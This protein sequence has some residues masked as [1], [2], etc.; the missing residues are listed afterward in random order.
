[1]KKELICFFVLILFSF[2]MVDAAII[3]APSCSYEDVSTAVNSANYEDTVIVPAGTCTWDKTLTITK[4][5]N[6]QGAGIDKTIVRSDGPSGTGVYTVNFNADQATALNNYAF[7]LS[8]FTFQQV[9]ALYGCLE[10]SNQNIS[11]ELTNVIVHDNKFIGR[12]GQGIGIT[13]D[14]GVFGV[15]YNNIIQDLSHSWRFLGR[16]TGWTHVDEWVPGSSNAMYYEDNYIFLTSDLDSSLIVSGGGGNR[17]VARYNTINLSTKPYN[18]FAQAYDI[19]GNQENNHGAGVGLEIY[20]NHRIS[21]SGRWLDHRG[22]KVF[23]FFNRWTESSG[24][25]SLNVWEEF[26]DDDFIHIACPEDRYART[27]AGNCVQRPRNSYYWRNYGG[28]DGTK[29][30]NQLNILFDHYS[31]TTGELNNPLLLL[32]NDG[33]FRDNTATFDG[34]ID[35]IGSCGY[36]NGPACTK[37]G[38]GC[39]TLEQMNAIKPTAP[40]LGFWVTNQSCTNL[41]DMTGKNPFNPL[42]GTLYRAESDGKGGYVWVAYYTPYIYPHPLRIASSGTNICGEGE[43]I[44]ECWCEGL[45]TIGYCYSGYYYSEAGERIE[46]PPEIPTSDIVTLQ[47]MLSAYQQ[48]KTNEVSLIY[49]LD[50]LRNWIVFW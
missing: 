9:S 18:K 11:H 4:G 29:L 15:I 2:P 5:I 39:G 19:H 20:G 33:W 26:D 12:S 41:T 8:G 16:I 21:T 50:K 47:D 14:N 7:R 22:G 3:N 31:R 34:T 37:S 38:I 46:P 35:P 32:E 6:L 42:S 30:S 25:G 17:Y 44:L 49:F 43:I 36:Y 10:L 40:D 45:K 1:M 27:A 48:Y 23:F 24:V 13:H 28:L